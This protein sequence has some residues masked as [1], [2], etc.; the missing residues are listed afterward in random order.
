MRS[1]NR[2]LWCCWCLLPS[3]YY[4]ESKELSWWYPLNSKRWFQRPLCIGVRFD[5]I[6][7]CYWKLSLTG[8]SWR[9]T[10]ARAKLYLS[11]RTR[12]RTRCIGRAN[13]LGC[14]WQVWWCRKKHLKWIMVLSSKDST[15]SDYSSNGTVAFFRLTMFQLLIMTL[16]PLLI[17]NP[18]I[19]RVG[20]G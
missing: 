6:A 8:T 1:A 16:L 11:S 5:F 3:C 19:C 15:V 4:N 14:S 12:Y 17:R 7:R 2:R 10:D 9:T 20:V 13:V 18:A